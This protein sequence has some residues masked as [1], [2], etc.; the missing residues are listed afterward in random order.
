MSSVP[1]CDSTV[2]W[3][4]IEPV[5]PGD[6]NSRTTNDTG[7]YGYRFLMTMAAIAFASP[8]GPNDATPGS[9]GTSSPLG[10]VRGGEDSQKKGERPA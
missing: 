6:Q 2:R 4:G 7:S 3:L 5:W 8:D 9:P 1:Q 10:V